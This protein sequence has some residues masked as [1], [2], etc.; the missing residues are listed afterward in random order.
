MSAVLRLAESLIRRP[1]VTPDDHGCQDLV[2]E[3]LAPL[4]FRAE[5][6]D[7]NGV[8]N[9][10]AVRTLAQPGPTLVFAGHT[11]V[12]PAGAVESWTSDPFEPTLRDGRLYGRGAADMK[13]SIAAFV[14][15]LEE[16]I[17]GG[18]VD[19][20][21]V[22]VLLTS[23]EEGPAVDGTVRVVERLAAAGERIDYCIVGEPTSERRF[24]DVYK[25]GRRGSLSGRLV[26]HGVQGHVAYPHLA[27]NPLHDL[28]PA[29]AELVRI[30]W[31]RGDDDFPP[32]TWQA[33]NLHAGTGAGNVIPASATLDFN[34]RFS[35]ASSVESLQRRFAER[36]DAH[37]LRY[38]L[39]WSPP[40]LPFRCAPGALADALAAAIRAETGRAPRASTS[41]GTS[42]GRFLARIC[43][44]VVE[45][46]PV[47]ES[48]H[49]VDESVGVDELEPLKNVYR[50]TIATLLH[51]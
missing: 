13:S 50:R 46:G 34:F 33:S 48:I 39:E 21:R 23:D 30:E 31:D 38:S 22:A 4:G 44:Q 36:L 27:R 47:N 24:G 16:A 51:G 41:G 49:R 43:P 3:R 37:G 17:G 29:L 25:N 18:L 42:D 10:W 32:T 5:R 15:A 26:V 19:H 7:A 11:D 40:A 9:L 35:P 28:A 45:F 8:R 6:I 14:V 12:V 1:S 20:G 2:L